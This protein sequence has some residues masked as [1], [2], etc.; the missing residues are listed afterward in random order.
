MTIKEE[1]DLHAK[2]FAEWQAAKKPAHLL[3]LKTRGAFDAL[4]CDDPIVGH[5]TTIRN[6]W[7]NGS[8]DFP[9]ELV[10]LITWHPMVHATLEAKA[11]WDMIEAALARFDVSEAY[12]WQEEETRWA[13]LSLRSPDDEPYTPTHFCWRVFYNDEGELVRNLDSAS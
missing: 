2:R 5:S 6:V 8:P 11:L 13:Y 7:W 9:T 12:Y 3:E 4:F 10:P 1:L